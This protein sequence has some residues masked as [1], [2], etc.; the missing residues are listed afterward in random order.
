MDSSL[1]C[2]MRCG[3]IKDVDP[4]SVKNRNYD[5]SS[6]G[7]APQPMILEGSVIFIDGGILCEAN[8]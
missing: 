4:A 8:S 1:T 6:A 3:K 2:I 5:G 7:F